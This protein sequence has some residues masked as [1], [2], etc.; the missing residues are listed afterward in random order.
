MLGHQ[1]CCDRLDCRG[2]LLQVIPVFYNQPV[3]KT[4]NIKACLGAE[5]IVFG[6]GGDK[7][8]IL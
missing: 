4:E 6:V 8:P 5:E 2:N 3:L 7:I 1:T